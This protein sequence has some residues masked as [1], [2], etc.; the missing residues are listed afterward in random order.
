MRL[1]DYVKKHCI[2][3][4]LI[5]IDAES[6]EYQVLKGMHNILSDIKPMLCIE[7]GDLGIDGVILSKKIIEFLMIKYSYKPY[8]IKKG[9]LTPH[10]L[11][12]KYNYTNLFFKK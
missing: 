1:D 4:K 12:E 8:E 3:P 9:I 10:K 6:A 11:K 2:I 7:L 5:K